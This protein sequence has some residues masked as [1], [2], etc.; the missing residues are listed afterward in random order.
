MRFMPTSSRPSSP[1]TLTDRHSQ[2][3]T[4]TDIPTA[5]AISSIVYHFMSLTCLRMMSRTLLCISCRSPSVPFMTYSTSTSLPS[6]DLPKST[7]DPMAPSIGPACV[8]STWSPTSRLS[9][10]RADR[11][12]LVSSG[13]AFDWNTDT[14]GARRYTVSRR[15]RYVLP[16][17]PSIVSSACLTSRSTFSGRAGLP[18][19]L[20]IC[21]CPR[22]STSIRGRSPP[23]TFPVRHSSVAPLTSRSI[24]SRVWCLG[25]GV[26]LT[27]RP[28]LLRSVVCFCSSIVK[29]RGSEW[30]NSPS[31][32][33]NPRGDHM[34]CSCATCT[35]G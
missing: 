15:N 8:Q 9:R 17:S 13:G 5:R 20:A 21:A 10:R 2:A 35:Q 6:S 18:P 32:E 12:F 1:R 31:L 22:P 7:T 19:P 11:A 24:R 14:N 29:S 23:L 27:T 28:F 26:G 25:C 16:L 34:P 33:R 4:P 30:R 3:H